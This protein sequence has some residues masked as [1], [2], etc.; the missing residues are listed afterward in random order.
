MSENNQQGKCLC[1]AVTC[2]ADS[3]PTT[4][5]A[6]HCNMCRQWGGGPL[7][8][9]ACGNGVR[10]DGGDRVS[11]YESSAWAERG[12][13]AVCGT[14]LFY[15]LKQQ[16][17]YFIPAGLFGDLGSVHFEREVFIDHKPDFYSFA[18]ATEK[19]TGE[20]LFAQLAPAE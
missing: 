9:V 19:L 20:E 10:F 18:N 12:F 6:C 4:V 15:R 14:H 1:G 5:E 13:C 2:V 16:G 17:H 8:V 3:V 7:F 11:V